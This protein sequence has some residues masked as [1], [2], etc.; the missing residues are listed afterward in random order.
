MAG[1][2]EYEFLFVV[3]GVSL[4]DDSA[5]A[6][7]TDAFDGILSWNRGLYRLAVSSQG[8]DALAALRELRA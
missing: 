3:D 7:L 4:N 5:V 1:Q 8:S 6:V 2:V